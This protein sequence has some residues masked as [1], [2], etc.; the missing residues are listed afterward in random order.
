MHNNISISSKTATVARHALRARIEKWS[1]FPISSRFPAELVLEA[2]TALAEIYTTTG[3][4]DPANE[5]NFDTGF[6]VL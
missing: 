4:A 5:V 2:A 1:R 3:Y 6:P